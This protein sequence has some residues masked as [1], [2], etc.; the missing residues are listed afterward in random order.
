MA[1]YQP[2]GRERMRVLA[3]RGGLASGE[4]RRLKR[5]GRITAEWAHRKWGIS[6]PVT[7]NDGYPA[8]VHELWRMNG[9]SL[10][11]A[12][13]EEILRPP[14]RRGGSHKNDWRCTDPSCRHLN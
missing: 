13:C 11:L 5:V 6:I 2:K 3:R 9:G 14:D 1:N 7:P 10:T 8:V 12:E 4:T